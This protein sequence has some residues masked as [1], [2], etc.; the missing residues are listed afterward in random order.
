MKGIN[1]RC[2]RGGVLSRSAVSGLSGWTVAVG[3]AAVVLG[4]AGRSAAA[5]VGGTDPFAGTAVHALVEGMPGGAAVS[6]RLREVAKWRAAA[7]DPGASA[8]ARVEAWSAARQGVEALLASPGLAGHPLRGVW[9]TDLA[10]MLL[11]GYLGGVQRSAGGFVE[12]GLPTAAQREAFAEAVPAAWGHLEQAGPELAALE[13][14]LR[15]DGVLRDRLADLGLEAWIF[16][17]YR[18]QK[19]VWYAAVAGYW[20]T[21][22]PADHPAYRDA[23]GPGAGEAVRAR[24]RAG[25]KARLGPILAGEVGSDGLR[26]RAESLAGRLAWRGGDAAAARGHFQRAVMEPGAATARWN[27]DQLAAWLGRATLMEPAARRAAVLR[28]LRKR[29]A[30]RERLDDRLLVTDALH[31]TLLSD[32]AGDAAAVERAYAVY[33]ELLADPSLGASAGAVRNLVEGRWAEALLTSSPERGDAGDR[34]DAEAM[35]QKAV[36]GLPAAVRA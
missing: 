23:V 24:L 29:S 19:T 16:D 2:R 31:R 20:M 14:R 34:R 17:Q 21:L 9:R 7:A 33:F 10:E 18:D 8:G 11:V 25:A 15:R 35:D 5:E 4:V 6:Q 3:V 32:A 30:V 13:D 27:S 26:L 36:R 22:L 12:F 1:L 28:E